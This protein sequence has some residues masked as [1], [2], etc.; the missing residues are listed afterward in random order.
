MMASHD[1]RWS[2][3]PGPIWSA[4]RFEGDVVA[5]GGGHDE[6]GGVW[7]AWAVVGDGVSRRDW[8]ELLDIAGRIVVLLETCF[9]AKIIKAGAFGEAA[10]RCL[11][12][13]G[14]IDAG[15]AEWPELG[16]YSRLEKRAA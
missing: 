12:R 15:A 2:D 3:Q 13:L 7:E 5:I 10:A 9:G 16:C 8:P 14:F 11:K 1:W 6:G 4:V